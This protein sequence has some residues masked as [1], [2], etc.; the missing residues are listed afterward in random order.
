MPLKRRDVEAALERKG[1]LAV[2][3]T[4]LSSSTKP[5]EELV[6]TFV[7]RLLMAE[8]VSTFPT[9]PKPD[10]ETM[11][12]VELPISGLRRLLAHSSRL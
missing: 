8:A 1:F 6:L 9:R 3:E 5:N 11:S 7:P 12:Y 10:G 4:T 2:K